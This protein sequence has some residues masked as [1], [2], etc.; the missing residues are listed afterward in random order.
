MRIHSQILLFAGAMFATTTFAGDNN[1]T[2]A[3]GE[4][5]W[6]SISQIYLKLEAVGYGNVEKIEREG[7]S[8]EVKAT[9]R[10]GQRVKLFVHP[11]TGEI[12][13]RR[14]HGARADKYGG[15]NSASG[16]RNSADCNERRCRDDLPQQGGA[17]SPAGD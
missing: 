1:P 14:Q 17:A 2:A 4:R 8:Y 6:L 15:N 13:D 10:N 7:G 3:G 9:D 12:V 5:Q 11:Q 16:Q